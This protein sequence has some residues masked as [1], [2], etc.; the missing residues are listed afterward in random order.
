LSRSIEAS[1]KNSTRNLE[2]QIGDSD[3]TQ[4]DR[5]F[6][7][8]EA[9]SEYIALES[10]YQDKYTDAKT[11]AELQA[12][13]TEYRKE[14]SILEA[15]TSTAV[16]DY[17]SD[18]MVVRKTPDWMAAG[19]FNYEDEGRIPD[20]QSTVDARAE[21][22]KNAVKT[23]RSAIR[24]E[25]E[26]AF[27]EAN[28]GRSDANTTAFTAQMNAAESDMFAASATGSTVDSESYSFIK[29]YAPLFFTQMQESGVPLFKEKKVVKGLGISTTPT[30][31]TDY[32]GLSL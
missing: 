28:G 16:G 2:V 24:R 12:A 23:L 17:V 22:S 14:K 15:R 4:D 19:L 6:V 20:R 13:K 18:Q 27:Y 7:R 26:D 9:G 1:K 21:E 3:L 25:A 32:G 5:D 8:R 11:I 31:A 30:P 10:E 29:L